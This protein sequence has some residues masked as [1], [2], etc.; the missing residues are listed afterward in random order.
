MGQAIGPGID[1]PET[2]HTRIGD[3]CGT[4]RV[5]FGKAAEQIREGRRRQA[6]DGPP[7]PVVQ[8]PL[9]FRKE[10]RQGNAFLEGRPR[11]K[12]Q[13][14][15]KGIKPHASRIPRVE[16]RVDVPRQ[17]ET[18][19]GL[20][21]VHQDHV[22]GRHIAA[23]FVQ[24]GPG[25]RR[26]HTGKTKACFRGGANGGVLRNPDVEEGITRRMR[27]LKILLP[28]IAVDLR[29][30]VAGMLKRTRK[31]LLHGAYRRID[32]C[33][34]ARPAGQGQHVDEIADSPRLGSRMAGRGSRAE[35]EFGTA[36]AATHL[37]A[38]KG[39]H[40]CVEAGAVASGQG[41]QAIRRGCI[42]ADAE[43]MAPLPRRS[44]SR[45]GPGPVERPLIEGIGCAFDKTAHGALP[46]GGICEGS[47]ACKIR[48]FPCGGA[49]ITACGR[50]EGLA[51]EERPEFVEENAE[52]KTV[53]YGMVHD[54]P[55]DRLPP[56]RDPGQTRTPEARRFHLEGF[57]LAA[58]DGGLCFVETRGGLHF[59]PPVRFVH[60]HAPQEPVGVLAEA[61][62]Q[63]LMSPD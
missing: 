14:A 2:M 40:E 35:K 53:A 30:G 11:Q 28:K 62:A 36:R 26:G 41:A 55:E 21:F 33:V 42:E 51:L 43:T 37:N 12:P 25:R 60:N 61:R 31:L 20:S 18:S 4:L 24:D 47:L 34:V 32:R 56:V 63:G 10:P 54:E 52:G 38:D 29:K 15:D 57:R 58:P 9:F 19:F 23:P 44:C 22:L 6:T 27:R 49:V 8:Q 45:V 7:L 48:R 5:R 1:R 3:N 17:G 39:Q 59:Q 50:R 13:P 46:V 16:R